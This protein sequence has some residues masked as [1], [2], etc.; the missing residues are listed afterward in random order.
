MLCDVY[1][2]PNPAESTQAI[3][4]LTLFSLVLSLSLFPSLNLLLSTVKAHLDVV[5]N[6]YSKANDREKLHI[7]TFREASLGHIKKATE[8]LDH[9]T[10][11][12]PHGNVNINI[13]IL[14]PHFLMI[15]YAM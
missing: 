14:S 4:S 5:N 1:S 12:Y 10:M 7:Q 13:Y 6:C 9:I 8:I 2:E 15:H 3:L 11:R